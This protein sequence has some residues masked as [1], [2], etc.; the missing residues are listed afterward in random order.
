MFTRR[1]PH[2]RRTAHERRMQARQQQARAAT[3]RHLAQTIAR[4]VVR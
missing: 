2:V 4:G 3:D 1:R